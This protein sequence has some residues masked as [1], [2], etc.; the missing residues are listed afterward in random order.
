[1][2]R[3]FEL[4]EEEELRV[5]VNGWH[6]VQRIFMHRSFQS[7]DLE[8][9]TLACCFQALQETKEC[10][11]EQFIETLKQKEIAIQ[12]GSHVICIIINI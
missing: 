11:E 5:L 9:A 7:S 10:S 8:V 6:A 12:V 3:R 2:L 1:M 4:Q